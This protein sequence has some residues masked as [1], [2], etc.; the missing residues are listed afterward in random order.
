MKE[1]V[2]ERY[3]KFLEKAKEKHSDRFI[4][5]IDTWVGTSKPL[6]ILCKV[7]GKFTISADLHLVQKNGG[8]GSCSLEEKG[9]WNKADNADLLTEFRKVHG[10]YY[11]Y[12]EFPATGR[13]FISIRC[14]SHGEFSQRIT[15]HLGGQGCPECGKLQACHN[16]RVTF[17]EFISRVPESFRGKFTYYPEEWVGMETKIRVTCPEHG[18]IYVMPYSF[19]G[20]S[21]GCK[22]CGINAAGLDR[23]TPDSDYIGRYVETG[24]PYTP[25]EIVRDSVARKT[26]IVL[27]C[28]DHG[29]FTKGI[30]KALEGSG[31]PKCKR[32]KQSSALED[33]WLDGL[34]ISS[35]VK[36]HRLV[37][38]STQVV[39]GYDPVTN[40]VY[41][42]HG[43][44][45]HG[46]PKYFNPDEKNPKTKV[47]FG[48]AYEKTQEISNH[49]Q[50]LGYQLVEVWQSDIFPE[51][52]KVKPFDSQRL[53]R[54]SHKQL[55]QPTT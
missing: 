15:S 41:Q 11:S 23:R 16:R 37:E 7:H 30:T 33:K 32:S 40:T 52:F 31:C 48:A 9:S 4:Y 17:A 3:K 6:S 29:K 12:G 24:Y 28:N 45:W 34:G 49:I 19:C 14:P 22:K 5:S 18:D 43:D 26:R 47:S 50:S 53:C 46:N 51:S 39:D 8:C 36:Q 13:G 20:S 2:V 54:S 1:Y 27:E 42:F 25:V 10:D 38:D 44:F 55:P 35:L 21:Y